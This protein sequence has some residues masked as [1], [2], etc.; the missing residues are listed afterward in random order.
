MPSCDSLF[1]TRLAASENTSVKQPGMV[2]KRFSSNY[3]TY[4][5]VI[6]YSVHPAAA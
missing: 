1:N 4:S 6:S 5:S 3:S 2:P